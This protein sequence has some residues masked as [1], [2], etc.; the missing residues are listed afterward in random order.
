MLRRAKPSEIGGIRRNPVDAKAREVAEP[1]VEAIRVEGEPALRRYAGQLGELREGGKLLFE[2]DVELRAA[3]NSIGDDQRE[4][5]ERTAA[6]VRAFAQ[7]QK[8]SISFDPFFCSALICSRLVAA[9]T[10]LLPNDAISPNSLSDF[11][12]EVL[13]YQD[14]LR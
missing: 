2:R 10:A 13:R 12:R 9:S 1:I 6:R 3:Y 8:N 14:N 11:R 4:M 7:A 5:L